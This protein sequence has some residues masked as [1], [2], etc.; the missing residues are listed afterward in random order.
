MRLRRQ[1]LTLQQH[2]FIFYLKSTNQKLAHY[3]Y[4]SHIL[5]CNIILVILEFYRLV[6]LEFY[7][8]ISYIL[9]PLS[10]YWSR[11]AKTSTT[12]STYISRFIPPTYFLLAGLSYTISYSDKIFWQFLTPIIN[13]S[14]NIR[15]ILFIFLIPPIL[16]Y[17]IYK[18][19]NLW[20][21]HPF[22]FW[23]IPET[24]LWKTQLLKF[25]RDI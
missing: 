18:F 5:R 14:I 3:L 19:Q 24:W 25:S 6:R 1:H 11:V 7:S 21:N 16:I 12:P 20:I 13:I 2:L 9:D 22:S 15:Y 23:K 17:L 4:H 8:Y 10:D